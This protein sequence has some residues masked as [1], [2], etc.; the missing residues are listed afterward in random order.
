[1]DS[2]TSAAAAAAAAEIAL[3]YSKLFH[4]ELNQAPLNKMTP[5]S[6]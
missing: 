1:M 4:Q 5:Y 3:I 2:A 6:G